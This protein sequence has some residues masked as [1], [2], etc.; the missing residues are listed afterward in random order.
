[1]TVFIFTLKLIYRVFRTLCIILFFPIKV[2]FRIL[3]IPAKII[4]NGLRMV[5]GKAHRITKAKLSSFYTWKKR[6]KN[7]I[8]KI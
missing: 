7:I 3:K 4:Y 2:L 8:K 1:M 5:F 6:F